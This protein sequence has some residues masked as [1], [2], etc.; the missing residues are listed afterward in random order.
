MAEFLYLEQ[1]VL[2]F[3]IDTQVSE[4]ILL[5]PSE[6]VLEASDL[7]LV[8]AGGVE[9]AF[10]IS[11]MGSQNSETAGQLC[12][13]G[14]GWS[15]SC[16]K[17][18]DSRRFFNGLTFNGEDVS[19]LEQRWES[20]VEEKFEQLRAQEEG[21]GIP[22]FGLSFV[23]G[24]GELLE[25]V[26]KKKGLGSSLLAKEVSQHFGDELHSLQE[27]SESNSKVENEVREQNGEEGEN[28]VPERGEVA[29]EFLG[30]V[31][32]ME[33]SE[34]P[35]FSKL[36]KESYNLSVGSAVSELLAWP[37]KEQY[38]RPYPAVLSRQAHAIMTNLRSSMK[39]FI[40]FQK[41][42]VLICAQVNFFWPLGS[43]CFETSFIFLFSK[44]CW[45][46]DV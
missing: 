9:D 13:S 18:S 23:S 10:L 24:T 27:Q 33:E 8:M 44:Y 26:V 6:R 28:N 36:G 2:L 5:N 12:V 32:E 3:A 41:K 4:S 11:G 46:C 31:Q 21:F 34:M 7:G 39:D 17:C 15:C 1:R 35:D 16:L 38:G 45:T 22:D 19:R 30:E 14:F 37:P 25:W 43:L 40:R 29:M 42:H 20:F